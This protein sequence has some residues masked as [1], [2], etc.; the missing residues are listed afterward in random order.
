MRYRL[1]ASYQGAPYEAGVGPTDADVVLFAACPPPEELGFEPA[2]GHWRKQ[3]HLPDVQTLHES[4]PV[5]IFRGERCIVLDDLG[6]GCTSPTSDTTR[7][8]PSRSATGKSTGGYS[9]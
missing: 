8:G 7:T 9:S 2:T 5:G 3:V 6:T 1:L 4:R